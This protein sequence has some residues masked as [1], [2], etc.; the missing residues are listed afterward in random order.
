[1]KW[2]Q[3]MQT[4]P[5]NVLLIDYTGLSPNPH[6]RLHIV[7]CMMQFTARPTGIYMQNMLNI[8]STWWKT[9]ITWVKENEDATNWR[10]QS[11]HIEL[12]RTYKQHVIIGTAQ[13]LQDTLMLQIPQKSPLDTVWSYARDYVTREIVL[14]ME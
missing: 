10:T 11:D 6:M 13:L 4:L 7:Y 8:P 2:A 5:E 12:I 1:M 9:F 14:E 3:A